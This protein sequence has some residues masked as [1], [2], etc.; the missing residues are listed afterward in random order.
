MHTKFLQA[1]TNISAKLDKIREVK[2]SM[3]SGEQA[4]Y[5]GA[6]KM[7]QASVHVQYIFACMGQ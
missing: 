3:K 5:V 7:T 1:G 2:V 6:H 4:S